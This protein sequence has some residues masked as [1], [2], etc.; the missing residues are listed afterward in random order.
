MPKPIR[1]LADKFLV[2]PKE[3][4]VAPPASPA[5][6]V[7]QR[8]LFVRG[9]AQAKR[10]ALRKL[11]D[12][13]KVRN[14][15]IFCNRKTD[16]KML[17]KSMLSHGYDAVALHGDMDQIDRMATLDKFKTDRAKYMVCSDVAARGIDIQ[18]LSHVFNFDVPF[19]ADDYVH[20]IGRTGRAG[21]RGKAFMLVTPREEKQL[22]AIHDLIRR[23]IPEVDGMGVDIGGAV[24]DPEKADT[25]PDQE[26]GQK[27]DQETGA[28]P[29]EGAQEEKPKRR[30]SPRRSPRQKEET[31]A[32]AP[33]SAEPKKE[34]GG[35]RQ[36]PNGD[37]DERAAAPR[38]EP[39]RGRGKRSGKPEGMGDHMPAF[40]ARP[41]R[42][43]AEAEQG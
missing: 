39:S 16:V 23:E 8:R 1:R 4:E 29:D 5:E 24:D 32:E 12:A 43:R 17:H 31:A 27:P 18:G 40:M 28:G 34:E 33:R 41:L 10:A 37:G 22:A 21:Q 11:I 20:R 15:L 42:P 35:D 9:D 38:R 7:E 30:R 6:T 2:D 25:K 14:A 19:N 36:L 26:T 3:V 13:E